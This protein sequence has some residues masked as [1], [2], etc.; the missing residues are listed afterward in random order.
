VL[1][2]IIIPSSEITVSISGLSLQFG[3]GSVSLSSA[4]SV[5]IKVIVPF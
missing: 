4:S 3:G 5:I 2:I 1:L